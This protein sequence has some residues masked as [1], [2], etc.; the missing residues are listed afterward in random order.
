LILPSIAVSG[1]FQDGSKKQLIFNSGF[2]S[3]LINQ[4]IWQLY[5]V[6][7][8]SFLNTHFAKIVA[9]YTVKSEKVKLF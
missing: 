3:Q 5:F 8:E 2:S 7:C 6:L 4:V 1:Y 9:N